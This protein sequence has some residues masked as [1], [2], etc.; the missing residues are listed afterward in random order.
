MLIVKR[1]GMGSIH[2]PGDD[3][4][5]KRPTLAVDFV[6]LG[7]GAR[8]AIIGETPSWMFPADPPEIDHLPFSWTLPYPQPFYRVLSEDSQHELFMFRFRRCARSRSAP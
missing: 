3:K 8:G 4:G 1:L 5:L 7:D 2:Y 6:I